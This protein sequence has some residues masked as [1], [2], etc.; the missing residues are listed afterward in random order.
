MTSRLQAHRARATADLDQFRRY[1]SGSYCEH[2]LYRRSGTGAIAAEHNR[3]A[4]ATMSLNYLTYGA[5]VEIVPGAFETFYMVETPLSGTVNLSCGR[6]DLVTSATT[7]AVISP[8]FA[9]RSRWS[10]TCGQVMIKIPRT[11]LERH[12]AN[13]LGRPL[14]S[15]L[16]F[17]PSMPLDQG[18]GRALSRLMLFMVDQFEDADTLFGRAPVS[19]EL[20]ELFLTT[21]L[22]GQPNT[23]SDALTARAGGATPR[24]VR[25][26]LEYIYAHLRDDIAVADLATCSGVG[27]RTLYAGFDRFV[28]MP[29]AALIR[30]L[31]LDGARDDLIAANGATVAEIAARWN[32][33]HF[34][35]FSGEYRRRFGERPMDTLRR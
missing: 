19:R 21:L 16:E 25:R 7:G 12:A 5:D 30:S 27:A 22:T 13:L 14:A 26:A 29:P 35:R 8:T 15:A 32:F 3:V 11:T 2:G 20:E 28:G 17:D 33:L 4:L 24:H 10:A 34:G 18:A 31:R 9:V 6:R 1:L 23:H